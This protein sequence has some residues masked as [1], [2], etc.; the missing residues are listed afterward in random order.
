MVNSW[1]MSWRANEKRTFPTV[2]C[3]KKLELYYVNKM[4]QFTELLVV[5]LLLL[6]SNVIHPKGYKHLVYAGKQ[7]RFVWFLAYLAHFSQFKVKID[8]FH[9]FIIQ[10]RWKVWK[11]V[12]A[13]SDKGT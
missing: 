8:S 6:H 3:T 9:T 2:T 12:G 11:S 7:I 10:G 1:T 13:R 4:K 5:L